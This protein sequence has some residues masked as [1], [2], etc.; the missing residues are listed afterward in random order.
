[1]RPAPI[2]LVVSG[3]LRLLPAAA[4]AAR[5]RRA[6]LWL[7]VHGIDAWEPVSRILDS[8][9]LR[10][11]DRVL[12]VSRLTQARVEAWSGLDADRFRLL[13]NC[14]DLDVFTPGPRDPHLASRY[15]IA[16]DATV[17]MTL[18]RL[19][20][21]ERYKGVD[22]V[23][24]ALPEIARN[25]PRLAYLVVGEGPDRTRLEAK[26]AALGVASRTIFAGRIPE[27]EKAAHYRLADAFV[28]PGR[29]EGF[30][31]VFL[32]AMACGVP[33]VGSL[34]DGSREA[35]RDGALGILVDPGD[36]A[37]IVAGILAAL[38][39]AKG[40]PPGLAYFS[41]PRFIERVH[42]LLDEAMAGGAE[43]RVEPR[44]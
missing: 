33:A 22:E 38:D 24:E 25:R 21:A 36:R 29:G 6:R 28:M 11:T 5:L 32:E 1:L 10:W 31:I 4:A 18:A 2:D 3:H 14:V 30:G 39:R 40:V 27:E 26:A 8:R 15:G 37:G 42:A 41:K 44:R 9:L 35:L 13:P 12:S 23:L 7:T 19:A 17:I 20:G 16:A 34:V 43:P